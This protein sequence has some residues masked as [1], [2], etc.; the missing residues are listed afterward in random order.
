MVV[1][2]YDI[3]SMVCIRCYGAIS[4]EL[5]GIRIRLI[6]IRVGIYNILSRLHLLHVLTYCKSKM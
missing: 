6:G 4:R 3:R 5:G 1:F 2:N